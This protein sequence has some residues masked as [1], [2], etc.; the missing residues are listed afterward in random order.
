MI[1]KSQRKDESRIKEASNYNNSE[2]QEDEHNAYTDD[3]EAESPE[4]K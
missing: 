3:F 1:N 4:L 2:I